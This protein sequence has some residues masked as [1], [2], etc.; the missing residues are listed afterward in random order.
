MNIFEIT[1]EHQ[2]WIN[3][4]EENEGE[5]TPEQEQ[6]FF[7]IIKTGEDKVTSLYYV[8]KNKQL[9]LNGVKSEIERITGIKKRLEGEMQRISRLI[10]MYMKFTGTEKIKKGVVDI[11]MAKK[12]D[13]VYQGE[14]PKT[15]TVTETVEKQK[16]AEF[17]DWCKENPEE[18]KKMF[19]AEFI[20][21]KSLRLK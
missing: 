1:K 20:E 10:E 2:E 9:E 13:F 7:E 6:K 19:G 15:F 14:F 8:W 18:A 21:G 17:K 12:T 16:L 4:L 5:L 11:I 3:L